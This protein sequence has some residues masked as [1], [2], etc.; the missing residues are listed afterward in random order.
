M[1][2]LANYS[3]V[4]TANL[5]PLLAQAQSAAAHAARDVTLFKLVAMLILL[6]LGGAALVVWAWL[7]LRVGRRQI[8]RR[9]ATARAATMPG[10][11]SIST[12]DWARK[13]LHDEQLPGSEGDG[14][15]SSE[16]T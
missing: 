7:T 16:S 6:V 13:P 8:R 1:S 3:I 2:L 12:D 5:V 15:Q 14:D 11:N 9:G 10:A 4:L